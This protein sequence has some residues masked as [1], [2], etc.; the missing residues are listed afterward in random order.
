MNEPGKTETP[1]PLQN[2]AGYRGQTIDI[3]ALLAE[4]QAAASRHG[5]LS[6]IFFEGSPF[7][8][9]ALRRPTPNVQRPRRVYISA[10]IHGDEP[11]GPLAMLRLLHD[12]QWPPDAELYALPCLNPVG[13]TLNSRANARG[14]D[15]N[16]AYLNPVVEEILA[17]VAWLERQPPFDLCLL[18]HEDWESRGFYL[19]EQN[20]EGR[21]SLAEK[22]I[23]A[24]AAVCPVDH[25]EII[26]GRPARNG[27]LRPNVDPKSRPDWPEAFYLIT[28]KTRQSYTLEAPS[29][30]PLATRVAALLAAVRAALPADAPWP[31]EPHPA[32]RAQCPCSKCPP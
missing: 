4:V 3:R 20:P 26:E 6:E 7:Q 5:W 32:A 23:Q 29:D 27:I 18:L 11:A 8:L 10:G 30:F 24:V 28:H 16:R 31:P 21:P 22:I 14:I 1:A 15:L 12:N 17:H 13:F 19:Y 9:S 25:S 2:A